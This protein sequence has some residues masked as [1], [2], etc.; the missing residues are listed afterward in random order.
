MDEQ[1]QNQHSALELNRIHFVFQRDGLNAAIEFCEGLVTHYR[2]CVT[3]H[4]APCGA[5]EY[6]IK[7]IIA[8]NVAK[9]FVDHF[10]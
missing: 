5:R 7:Y 2:R 9:C 10:K 6:R 3:N 8:I 1:H 4:H